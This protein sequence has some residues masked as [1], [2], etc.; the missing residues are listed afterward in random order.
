MFM[1][2][3]RQG[4]SGDCP[5]ASEH[6]RAQH[7][8]RQPSSIGRESAAPGNRDLA[9]SERQERAGGAS[10]CFNYDYRYHHYY[11]FDYYYYH[12]YYYRYYMLSSRGF[13]VVLGG[14]LLVLGEREDVDVDS[15]G[16]QQGYLAERCGV[17]RAS[18]V[19]KPGRSKT[20]CKPNSRNM[21][22][23]CL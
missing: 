16:G 7:A 13:L 4:L 14:F 23:F 17:M 18:G 1:E 15:P 12:Y 8:K 3:A 22:S 10:T 21:F 19:T 5:L 6:P 9:D 11:H 20:V 2:V